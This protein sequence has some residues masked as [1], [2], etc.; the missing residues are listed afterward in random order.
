VSAAYTVAKQNRNVSL[1]HPIENGA[2]AWLDA[3]SAMLRAFMLIALDG[4]SWMRP[5]LVMCVPSGTT[6]AQRLLWSQCAERAM[7]STV[8]FVEH[9]V[10]SAVGLGLDSDQMSTLTPLTLTNSQRRSPREA[11]KSHGDADKFHIPAGVA[12]QRLA[13]PGSELN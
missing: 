6:D 3:A 8:F 9:C 12:L 11:G 5:R 4:R 10:A 7:A 13:R 1:V 2:I